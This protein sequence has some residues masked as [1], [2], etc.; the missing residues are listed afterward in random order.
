MINM[1]DSRLLVGRRLRGIAEALAASAQLSLNAI[2]VGVE[3]NN[4]KVGSCNTLV[5]LDGGLLKLGPI[6]R[7]NT[8]L[9]PLPVITKPPIMTLSPVPTEPRV[10]RFVRVTG[11]V[12]PNSNAPMSGASCLT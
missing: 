1:A 7:T 12:A 4:D 3:S 2:F 6:A 11:I 9:V 5:R 10:E 8:D